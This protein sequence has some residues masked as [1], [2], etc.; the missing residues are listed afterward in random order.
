MKSLSAVEIFIW[1]YGN[2]SAGGHRRNF[3]TRHM[4]I[5]I[6]FYRIEPEDCS[7]IKSMVL[8]K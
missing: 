6:Y 4:S 2:Y 1:T 7:D 3:N 8:L 5:E